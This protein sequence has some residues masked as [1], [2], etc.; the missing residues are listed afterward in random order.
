MDRA[1]IREGAAHS[2]PTL[3]STNRRIGLVTGVL[4]NLLVSG[5]FIY[6]FFLHRFHRD[7][8]YLS[9]QEDEYLEWMTF[10]AFALAGLAFLVDSIRRFRSGAAFPWFGLCVGFF[11]WWV[12]LEEISWGQ[13]ILGYRP[14]TYF[15]E[16][17]FQ[18]EFNLHNIVDSSIR[19]LGLNAVIIGYGIFLPLMGLADR[20]K[21]LLRRLAVSAA[22]PELIPSFLATLLI[23]EFYPPGYLTELVELVLGLGFLL[24]AS[25]NLRDWKAAARWKRRLASLLAPWIVVA[26]LG[27]ATAAVYRVRSDADPGRAEAARVE[28]RALSQDFLALALQLTDPDD[29][30]T[31]CGLHQRL[32]TFVRQGERHYLREGSFSRL[33]RQ[34]LPEERAAFFLDPWNSPYW[35]RHGC[36]GGFEWVYVYSFGPNRRRDSS[37]REI[38]GDDIGVVFFQRG[39]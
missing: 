14:P 12:A 32:Y 10:W 29:Y 4:A 18:Q 24:T 13:R 9:V 17:N 36:Q 38:L 7:L 2:K 25:R 35:I 1:L 30:L 16:H 27:L 21:A 22:P 5:V 23:Y 6:A 26:G 3:S 37:R 33:V 15:L 20:W 8:Y 34:G 39:Q 31:E 19:R 28:V 11:C